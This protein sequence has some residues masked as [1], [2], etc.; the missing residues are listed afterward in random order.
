MTPLPEISLRSMPGY[1]ETVLR[2]SMFFCISYS[3]GLFRSTVATVATVV[4]VVDVVADNTCERVGVFEKWICAKFLKK[5]YDIL[6]YFLVFI[7][8]LL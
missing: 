5:Y 1:Q 4:G 6:S 8:S 2:T 3:L 7:L